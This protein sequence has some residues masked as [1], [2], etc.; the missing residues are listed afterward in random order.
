MD[1][2]KSRIFAA[3]KWRK[4][5]IM[6]KY[7]IAIDDA[8]MEEVR[9]SITNGMDED[10]WVQLQV[11]A[12]F[13]RMAASRR[14]VSFDDEYMANLINLSAPAWEGVRDADEWIHDLRGEISS[15]GSC[16]NVYASYYSSEARTWG[17][18]QAS[19]YYTK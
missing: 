10:A 12:L 6:C 2:E 14:K 18:D 1:S 19:C 11:E 16:S 15:C 17:R 4:E 5:K 8:V 7:N 3:E 13:S 9:P